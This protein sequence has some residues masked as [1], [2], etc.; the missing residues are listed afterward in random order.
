MLQCCQHEGMLLPSHEDALED[1]VLLLADGRQE[2]IRGAALHEQGLIPVILVS[3]NRRKLGISLPV[4]DSVR[5]Q[6]ARRHNEDCLDVHVESTP[7]PV[8]RVAEDIRAVRVAC[9][10][11]EEALPRSPGHRLDN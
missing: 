3:S 8:L 2:V 9:Q 6:G 11:G 1:V 4:A 7:K 5:M 10:L